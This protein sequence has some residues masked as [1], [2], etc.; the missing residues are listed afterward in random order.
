MILLFPRDLAKLN[1]VN[2]LWTLLKVPNLLK[3]C[4]LQSPKYHL[5]KYLFIIL[6]A[7]QRNSSNNLMVD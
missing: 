6:E 2:M 4:E 5:F 3:K 1:F 7:I